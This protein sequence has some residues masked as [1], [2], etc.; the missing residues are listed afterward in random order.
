MTRPRLHKSSLIVGLLALALMSVIVLPGSESGSLDPFLA[1]LGIKE[2]DH[3]WPTVFLHRPVGN[4][5][6]IWCQYGWRPGYY[7]SEPLWGVPW[8]SWNAWMPWRDTE[9]EYEFH[10]GA[11]FVDLGIMFAIVGMSVAA[12]EWRRR[13][14][15]RVFQFRVTELLLLTTVVAMALGWFGYKKIEHVRE[16]P[17]ANTLLDAEGRLVSVGEEYVVP[18]WL[19][20]L[21]GE[22]LVPDYLRRVTVV[23]IESLDGNAAA[24]VEWMVP[25]LMQLER[26]HTIRISDLAIGWEF[27]FPRFAAI[28]QIRTLDLSDSQILKTDVEGA[29]HL[30]HMQQIT[31]LIVPKR[32]SLTPEALAIIRQEMPNC[33]VVDEV[34]LCLNE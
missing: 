12:W 9:T 28:S 17:H 11:L 2:F 24:S 25:H 15:R 8:L 3:G 29:R 20:R 1:G 27:P 4:P 19:R 23:N 33:E 18:N 7:P 6:F 16:G 30:S 5:S 10:L 26:C 31:R 32:S 22:D 13:R 34:D 21:V 14:R